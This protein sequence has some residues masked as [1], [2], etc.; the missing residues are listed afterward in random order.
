MFR[1]ASNVDFSVE[2]SQSIL[3]HLPDLS[4]LRPD[5]IHRLVDVDFESAIVPLSRENWVEFSGI[6]PHKPSYNTYRI[7]F[8]KL[9]ETLSKIAST[10]SKSK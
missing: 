1:F 4:S 10:E 3:V 5:D 9:L 8:G 7:E 2:E 6:R